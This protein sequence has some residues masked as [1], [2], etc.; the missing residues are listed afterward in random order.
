LTSRRLIASVNFRSGR[1]FGRVPGL[2]DPAV[3]RRLGYPPIHIPGDRSSRVILRVG[4]DHEPRGAQQGAQEGDQ[5][6]A[7][8]PTDEANAP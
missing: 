3:D 6:A 4:R 5:L 2:A 8:D 7:P 1:T